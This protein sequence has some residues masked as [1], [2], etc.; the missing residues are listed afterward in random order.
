MARR[1]YKTADQE[2]L[3]LDF[4]AV[5]TAADVKSRDEVVGDVPTSS[6]KGYDPVEQTADY[7]RRA[8]EFEEAWGTTIQ[9]ARQQLLGA[10]AV[11][12]YLAFFL[13][14]KQMINAGE[15]NAARLARSGARKGSPAA[16]A[17]G[18]GGISRR[19]PLAGGASSRSR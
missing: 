1:E 18:T 10:N 5:I 17:V 19:A 11:D 4:N 3:Q 16:I 7:M 14:L 13:D 9:E 8:V 15:R 2:Q 12:L 6:A